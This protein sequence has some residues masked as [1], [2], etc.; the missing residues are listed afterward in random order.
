MLGQR[1]KRFCKG[2]VHK[3][4]FHGQLSDVVVYRG[5][6]NAA[7]IRGFISR[8][9]TRAA[10]KGLDRVGGARPP[11]NMRLAYTSRQYGKEEVGGQFP[12]KCK[13]K[14]PPKKLTGPGGWMRWGGT[15]D[16]H[17]NSFGNCKYDDQGVGDWTALRVDPKWYKSYPLM[18]T[19]RTSPQRTNCPWC[20]KVGKH[21]SSVSYIDGCAIRFKNEQASAGF[22]GFRYPRSNYKPYAAWNGKAMPGRWH[23]RFWYSRGRRGRWIRGKHIRGTVKLSRGNHYGAHWGN[24]RFRLNDGTTLYCAKG[25]IWLNVRRKLIGKIGGIAGTGQRGKEW[26][27]GPNRKAVAR[28]WQGR[29]K[30]KRRVPGMTRFGGCP[31]R[32]QYPYRNSPWNGNGPNKPIVQWFNSWKAD[33]DTLP[34]AFGYSRGKSV[35]WFNKAD[36]S[37]P[38]KGG[39]SKRPSGAKKKAIHACR[40]L[41]RNKKLHSKCIFDFLVL[42]KKGVKGGIRDGMA[43][44]RMKGVKAT[45]QSVRDVSKWRNNAK[46]VGHP[47]WGCVNGLRKAKSGERRSKKANALRVKRMRARAER[48]KAK[49]RKAATAARRKKCNAAMRGVRHWRTRH[50]SLEKRTK[51]RYRALRQ[52]CG[53]KLKMVSGRA[54]ANFK[55]L[56]AV[57]AAL[58]KARAG[59]RRTKKAHRG[60]AAK[61]KALDKIT[62]LKEKKSKDKAKV[63]HAKMRKKHAAALAAQRKK[64]AAAR[65]KDGAA[66]GR[67]HAAAMAALRKKNA[68]A[69]AARGR[70]HAA[71]MAALRKKHASGKAQGMRKAH[72]RGH[73]SG[74]KKGLARCEPVNGLMREINRLKSRGKQESDTKQ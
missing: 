45:P 42:G 20:Q 54:L 9:L 68:A 43:K 6:L 7:R 48:L 62:K 18:V 29:V 58:K 25:N 51:K 41:I 65:K 24:A 56:K 31:P 13:L 37:S 15:G 16:V 4:S 40:A 66:R 28:N 35:H 39:N 44:R 50:K 14:K 34:S 61:R 33:G 55:K 71:A 67:K 32:Y 72:E 57:R 12:P 23:G 1:A 64:H 47:S 26:I 21:G 49:K 11:A 27:A 22:G 3:Q 10:M 30:Y 69:G 59:E 63:R 8:P 74:F 70:K 73:K 46:W 38:P 5:A 36:R 17:Y 53:K 52:Q 19:F 2:R 60:A